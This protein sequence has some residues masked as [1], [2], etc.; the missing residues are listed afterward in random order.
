M[1]ETETILAKAPAAP[2][3]SPKSG[4]ALMMSAVTH[5]AQTDAAKYFQIAAN[6]ARTLSPIGFPAYEKPGNISR[7]Y[8]AV[9][10]KAIPDGPHRRVS[11]NRVAV[12][13]NSIKPQRNHLSGRPIER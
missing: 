5:P 1:S 13:A 6:T 3:A 9:Q 11:K 12:H 10:A 4:I 7:K 8:E 2:A